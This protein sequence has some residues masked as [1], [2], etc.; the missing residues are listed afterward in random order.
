MTEQSPAQTEQ[1]PNVRRFI[2]RGSVLV[3]KTFIVDVHAR[4]A[5]EACRIAASFAKNA[6][7][8]GQMRPDAASDLWVASV[9]SF[10]VG[11]PAGDGVRETVPPAF[12]L[13][14]VMFGDRSK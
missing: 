11:E 10:A 14:S 4:S 2:V 8:S 7:D 12:S 1:S 13:R 9:S 5:D 3:P 6:S